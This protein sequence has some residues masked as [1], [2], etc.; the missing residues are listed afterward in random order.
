M[1]DQRMD[2][3]FFRSVLE[4][5]GI[6]FFRF[7]PVQRLWG[8]W[9]VAVNSA[10]VFFIGRLEAQ[11]VLAAV[12][13]ALSGQALIY[14]RRRFIRALGTT[15]ALWVPM[16]AWILLRQG[17]HPDGDSAFRLWI[18]ALVATNA[19]S[20]AIDAWDLTRYLGGERSPYYAW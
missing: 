13:V 17:T 2:I 11:V 6:V 7:R 14:Q 8:Y 15:H 5:L 16:L 9:L 20:L 10:G 12:A 19:L 3:G 18:F 1:A 4:I